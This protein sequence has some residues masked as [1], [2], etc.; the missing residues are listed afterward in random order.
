V[1]TI[2]LKDYFDF[3]DKSGYTYTYTC[4]N[5]YHE[6]SHTVYMRLKA[7]RWVAGYYCWRM[8]FDK[9]HINAYWDPEPWRAN[10]DRDLVFYIEDWRTCDYDAGEWLFARHFVAH[11][12]TV[13]PA[14]GDPPA[15]GLRY[16]TPFPLCPWALL[17]GPYIIGKRYG[18]TGTEYVWDQRVYTSGRHPVHFLQNT[19]TYGDF[20]K[21][22]DVSSATKYGWYMAIRYVGSYTCGSYTADTFRVRYIEAVAAN[23]LH[24]EDWYF[25]DG[26]G[27]VKIAMQFVGSG[28]GDG[29]YDDTYA[30]SDLH[31]AAPHI[32][33]VCTDIAAP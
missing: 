17:L 29:K 18:D 30:D 20:A 27:L 10:T 9:D 8:E 19:A 12:M 28:W 1:A 22:P 31:L 25:Q 16:V 26:N 7:P 32:E 11:E 23:K 14:T 24:V 2:D 6:T 21:R 4:T 33:M 13:A 5:N 15:N 3:A